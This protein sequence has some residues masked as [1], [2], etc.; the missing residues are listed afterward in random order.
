MK[1]RLSISILVSVLAT[2]G[3]GCTLRGAPPRT[4][5]LSASAPSAT[6]PHEGPVVGVG[7]VVVPTYLDRRA[8]VLHE[9]AD[10]EI[11]LAENHQWAEPIKDGVARV[12]AENLTAMIPTDAALVYPWRSPRVVTYRVTLEIFRFDGA[13]G[14]PVV[15]NVR[16]RLLDTDGKELVLR[17]VTLE[18]RPADATYAALVA[19]H[20]RLLATVSRDIATV[21]RAQRGG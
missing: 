18:E 21:I 7:P 11:R 14:S 5:I 17:T 1:I 16:W 12:V 19:S 15:L 10:G 2:V 4:Y 8:I 9:L 20:D 6:G 3:V 13:L